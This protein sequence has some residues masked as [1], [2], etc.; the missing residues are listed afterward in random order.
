MGINVSGLGASYQSQTGNVGPAV[1]YQIWMVSSTRAGEGPIINS[2]MIFCI[3]REGPMDPKPLS[4]GGSAKIL[5][6][7]CEWSGCQLLEPGQKFGHPQ[8]VVPTTVVSGVLASAT[9]VSGV[10]YSQYLGRNS[11]S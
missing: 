1:I 4:L 7:Q 3:P 11:V 2:W 10:V 8:P 6:D 5:G 9:G